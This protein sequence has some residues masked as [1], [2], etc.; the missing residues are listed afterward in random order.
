[1]FK[2]YNDLVLVEHMP[3]CWRASHRAAGNWGS[4]PHN[5]AERYLT[6]RGEIFWRLHWS[7]LP[8]FSRDNAYSRPWGEYE[9]GAGERG[10]SAS[11][12]AERLIEYFSSRG[13][14]DD[15]AVVVF[16]GTQVGGG[17]D[18]EPLVLPS[19]VIAW[20]RWSDLAPVAAIE[21]ELIDAETETDTEGRIR[22]DAARVDAARDRLAA[23]LSAVGSKR[24]LR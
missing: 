13:V 5:G 21:G 18:N 10:Y 17:P 16:E 23:I 7:D 24:R 11:E 9:R 3:D 6:H 20:L 14:S 15:A 19:R 4:Y 2:S 22:P 12:S 8:A 1:M